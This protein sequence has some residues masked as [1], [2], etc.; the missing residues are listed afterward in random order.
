MARFQLHRSVQGRGSRKI[1]AEL[2]AKVGCVLPNDKALEIAVEQARKRLRREGKLPP[3]KE[4][5]PANRD[6]QDA[7]NAAETSPHKAAQGETRQENLAADE[8]A[9]GGDETRD[10]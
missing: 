5:A 4:E 7:G 1:F 10:A 8:A 2:L 9:D 3:K 6:T